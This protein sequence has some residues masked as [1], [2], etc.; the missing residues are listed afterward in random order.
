VTEKHEIDETD[1]K[2]ARIGGETMS[3]PLPD[4]PSTPSHHLLQ[5]HDKE[6]LVH[7][8][9][10]GIVEVTCIKLSRGS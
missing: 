3:E 9:N 1:M 6:G 5:E 2:T 7:P 10:M 8:L 4:A